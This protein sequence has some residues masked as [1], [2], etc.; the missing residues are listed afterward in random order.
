MPTLEDIRLGQLAVA[1]GLAQPL[2]VEECLAVQHRR[3]Q[4]NNYALLGDILVTAVRKGL[5]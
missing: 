2:E 4:E 5:E 3:E 1:H